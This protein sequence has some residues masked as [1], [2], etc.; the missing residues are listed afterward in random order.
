MSSS[1]LSVTARLLVGAAL[2][3][4][5]IQSAQ[6]QDAPD[7]P[8]A[9]AEQAEE[10]T[11][12]GTRLT[13]D[14]NAVAPSPVSTVTTADVRQTGQVDITEAL[15]E[16]PALSAS[17]TIADSL[18]NGE[19]GIGQATLNLRGLGAERTLVVV[20]GRRHVSGVAGTQIV[21]VATI[22]A[23]LID[24]VEVLTGGA[25]AVYGADAVTGV[26]NFVLKEDFEGLDINA[27]QGISGHGDGR[28]FSIDA[29]L[30]KNFAGGRGNIAIA[31]SYATTDELVQ[32]DRAYTRNNARYNSGQ[33]YPNPLRRFQQGDI[34]GSATPNFASYF[35]LPNRFPYGSGIPLP[36]SS[37]YNA[38]FTGG[39]SPTAAEQALIDRAQAA[40]S[41]AF[42]SYPA[43][44]ISSTSGL[45]FRNDFNYFSTD[46][47]NN[48]VADCDQSYI[49]FNFAGC[50]VSNGDGTVRVFR[51]GVIA[52]ST[53]QFGGDGAAERYSAQSLVPQNTRINV[54]LLGSFEFSPA[55]SFF[56]EGKYVRTETVSNNP[57]NTFYDSLFVAPD[58]PY[59]P[60]ALLAEAIDAGGLRVSR[61]FTNL[62]PGTTEAVRDT[63]RVVA[64][65]K[66]ELSPHLRYEV[67][68]NYGRTDSAVTFSNTVLYDRLFA[69]ID[70][71]QG[72]NGPRCR[73][74]V[75]PTP[76]VGSE[77]FPFIEG[78]FYTF[79]PGDGTC[80][81]F[82]LFSGAN[83]IN[84]AAVDFITVPTTN[85]SKLEQLVFSANLIGDTG[86]FL[87]LPGGAI[88]FA[89]GAEYREERSTN[90]FN[91]YTLGILQI[92]TVNG[93]AGDFI[94]D[95][96]GNQ[97]LDFDAQTRTF[98]SGGRY[99]VKEVYG[100]LRLPLLRDTPFFKQLEVSA[101]ARY[102]DYSTVGSTF[103]WNVSGIYAPVDDLKLRGTYA[104]AIRAPNISELFDPQQGTVFRPAD[105]CDQ[106]QID[107]LTA[108]GDPDVQNRISNCQA[109]GLPAGFADP[110]TARFSGTTG[111]NPDLQ[112]EKA[113]TYT[114]GA[115]LT[116][117]F[118]PGFSL[119]GD[120]YSI[121][122]DDAI[123]AVSAQD[124]VD[125]CYD[126]STLDNIYCALFTRN[127]TVG[128]PTFLGL[129]FLRQTQLNFGSIETAGIDVTLAYQ[130]ALGDNRFALRASGNWT[131]KLDFFF[132]P[133]DP[134]LND[135]E[136]GE[137]GRPEFGA[138]GSVAW[139]RG[140]FSLGY[141]IQYIDGQTLQGVEVETADIV[142]GPLGYAD[143]KFVH[144]ISFNVEVDDRFT[145]Y[146]GINNLTD[147]EPYPTNSAYPV[148]PYGRF[149][150]LGA[151]IKLPGF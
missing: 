135:E 51:D 99:D 93:D 97:S 73:S 146:G 48:G 61:D 67:A 103:T 34:T 63:Y 122:I 76:Y 42:Q 43:F 129:N 4:L 115:V 35:S 46:L 53:N 18:E 101:A 38:I 47:D 77:A 121:K 3:P 141:R 16:I 30:G 112:E 45:I 98:N 17:G 68:G 120:Y 6:A 148:S 116:P 151:N 74:D 39:R 80:R 96:S 81:P 130:F 131:E 85:R 55:A 7:L 78:G 40:P 60:A 143:E 41:L 109:D 58:N 12:T 13:R 72:P 125:N 118:I 137:E 106:A 149:F 19:G 27:Q 123:A 26:V 59:I 70:V 100:E 134:T 32:G 104:R 127:R 69:A 9:P 114:F 107:A 15:R 91:P 128:S 95:I 24:R 8:Q 49:G 10:I 132:D 147:V 65:L 89:V 110:L 57:Y 136:L 126:S 71:V 31:A 82:S 87:N 88:Q 1:T 11:V 117:S 86:G 83:D 150:F 28:T 102:S 139:T 54:N 138:T 133:S 108:A 144:D 5:A 44:A 124:I 52:S 142:A 21:D 2:L 92:D 140:P 66:G 113:T 37:A 36:G 145:L 22:P 75:D 50:Y 33:T 79:N 23:A 94:G 29:T 25:S 84:Q 56:F 111:G 62:G 105:P 119:S 90:T 64:G 14:A 20:N